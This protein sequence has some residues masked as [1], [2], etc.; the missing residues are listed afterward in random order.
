VKIVQKDK[1]E[2]KMIAEKTST[3]KPDD[4]MTIEAQ[5]TN[6][7]AMKGAGGTSVGV[8]KPTT[9]VSMQPMPA[10]QNSL[11]NPKIVTNK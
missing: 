6:S 7:T 9:G 8:T 10:T 1:P 2:D 5:K 3:N 4:K 11:P